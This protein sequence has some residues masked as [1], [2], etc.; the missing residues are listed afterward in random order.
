MACQELLEDLEQRNL[1]LV[2][3][4]ELREWYRYHHLFAEALRHRF[5][6]LEPDR[7]DQVYQRAS[8]WFEQQGLLQEA[9]EYALDAGDVERAAGL[10]EQLQSTALTSFSNMTLWRFLDRLPDEVM[11]Q[12]PILWHIKA[13]F[14]LRSGHREEG[15]HWLDTVETAL[16]THAGQ[17]GAQ[18]LRGEIAAARGFAASFRGDAVEVIARTEAA[19]RELDPSNVVTRALSGLTLARGYMAHGELARAAD[20][21][22]GASSVMR[23]G[24]NAYVVVRAMFG[25]SQMERAQGQLSRAMET[26]RQAIAWSAERGHPYPGAGILQA[27]VAD[28]LRERHHL[29]PALHFAQEGLELCRQ[30]E[31]DLDLD[32]HVF[33]LFTLARIEQAQGHLDTALALVRQTQEL[34]MTT[35]PASHATALLQAYEAQLW[36]LQD[37]LAAALGC[38]EKVPLDQRDEEF[39]SHVDFFVLR[40]ELVPIV[41]IQMLMAQALAGGGTALLDQALSLLEVEADTASERGLLWLQIKTRILQAIAHNALRHTERA[42]VLLEEALGLGQPE[43]YV[44]VFADEGAPIATLLRGMPVSD[45]MRGYVATLLSAIHPR[46]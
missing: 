12:H 23:R 25:Q 36:R 5:R 42:R 8:L 31:S 38:A 34:V 43:G 10:I 29:E 4:D 11:V 27:T 3:L 13:W 17:E 20:A 24:G 14:L 41:P 39:R 9:V 37:N 44:R 2:A 26:C 16:Q 6:Q 45:A 35:E 46:L 28:I 30:V 32:A 19:L 22:A 33:A 15:E 1:F 21:F 7:V 18:N 40:H